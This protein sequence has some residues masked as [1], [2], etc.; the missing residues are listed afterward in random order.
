LSLRS[1]HQPFVIPSL[2]LPPCMFIR[3]SSRSI[4]SNISATGTRFH[5][6]SISSTRLS[7]Y[8]GRSNPKFTQRASSSSIPSPDDQPTASSPVGPDTQPIPP[9]SLPEEGVLGIEKPKR[10]RT[11][12][13]LK[14][15]GDDAADP[16]LIQNGNGGDGNSGDAGGDG[17]GSSSSSQ[18]PVSLDILWTPEPHP[19]ASASS[20]LQNLDLPPSEIFEDVLDNLHVALHPQ[21]QHRATYT[22]QDGSASSTVEPTLALYCPIEGG[23]YVVDETVKEL[24]RRVGADVVVLDCVKL[25]AGS[26]GQ[27]GSGASSFLSN[28]D[29]VLNICAKRSCKCASTT[30]SSPSFSSFFR[31]FTDIILYETPCLSRGGGG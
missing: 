11:V 15:P 2:P 28:R 8:P 23:D 3:S 6:A 1:A 14:P 9:P 19:R 20:N 18:L 10:K 26:V 12:I 25:A 5:R 30:R 24:A 22:P 13:H 27:F 17:N 4:A 29:G 16:P 21:T 7:R 31:V